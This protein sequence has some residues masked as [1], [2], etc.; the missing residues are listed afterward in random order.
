MAIDERIPLKQP[1]PEGLSVWETVAQ[2]ACAR[3]EKDVPKVIRT[4]TDFH[5]QRYGYDGSWATLASHVL[6]LLWPKNRLPPKMEEIRTLLEAYSENLEVIPGGPVSPVYSPGAIGPHAHPHSNPEH[7]HS[8]PLGFDER[9]PKFD[10]TDDDFYKDTE[11]SKLLDIESLAKL[12]DTT[13]DVSA[14][15]GVPKPKD[16]KQPGFGTGDGGSFSVMGGAGGGGSAGAA[17]WQAAKET[18]SVLDTEIQRLRTLLEYNGIDPDVQLK[19][20]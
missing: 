11:A 18:L 9:E 3:E 13:P 1:E 7:A 15:F 20:D 8:W 17:G 19:R 2:L 16:A 10:P 14:V 5:K 12:W 4:I 6:E